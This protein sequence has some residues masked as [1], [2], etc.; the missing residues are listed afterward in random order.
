M[1]SISTLFTSLVIISTTITLLNPSVFADNILYTGEILS[2]GQSL[3]YG[4]YKLTMQRDCNLVLYDDGHAE[5][6]TGTDNRGLG[7]FAQMQSDGNFVLYDGSDLVLWAS[8]TDRGQ[9]NCVLVLQ[10]DRNVVIYGGVTWASRT[11]SAGTAD[12]MITARN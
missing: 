8:N 10:R 11:N 12:A 6:S 7:C 9:G 3:T 4:R 2:E 1:A 5:W